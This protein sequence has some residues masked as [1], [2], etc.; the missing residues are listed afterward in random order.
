MIADYDDAE[1]IL[2][3]FIEADMNIPKSVKRDV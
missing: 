3:Y 2:A 1:S